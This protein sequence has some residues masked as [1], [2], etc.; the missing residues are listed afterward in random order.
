VQSKNNLITKPMPKYYV[1]SGQIKYIVDRSDHLTAI[2]DTLKSF[3]GKGLNTALK[4]CVSEVGWNKD[5][6]CY[7][8]DEFLKKLNKP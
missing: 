8:T 5:L 4:I 1:K 2:N 6:T 3:K 7:D